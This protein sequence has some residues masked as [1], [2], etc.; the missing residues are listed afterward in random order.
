MAGRK[1]VR[2]A[3]VDSGDHDNGNSKKLKKDAEE[4]ENEEG[5]GKVVETEDAKPSTEKTVEVE[6]VAETTVEPESKTE[7]KTDSEVDDGAKNGGDLKEGDYGRVVIFGS[8]NWDLTGRKELPKSAGKNV[9]TSGK[10]LWGP[11]TWS[12]KTRIKKAVSSCTACHS[13]IITEDGR[14][15]TFGRNDKGQLGLGDLVTRATPVIVDALKD[16]TIIDAACGKGHTLFLTDK[17]TVWACGDNK[18]G[19]LGIGSQSQ[20]VMSPSKVRNSYSFACSCLTACIRFLIQE[21]P[22]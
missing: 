10:N 1:K 16:Y 6:K 18:M 21:S 4:L 2:K 13:I 3:A 7:D 5:N 11:H 8:T 15:M 14:A 9:Q 12:E 17:G 22:L 19:Q 20:N